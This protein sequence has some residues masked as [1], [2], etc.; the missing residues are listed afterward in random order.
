MAD[1]LGIYTRYHQHEVTHA[2]L[3]LADLAVN[4][5]IAVTLRACDVCLREVT[6]HWDARVKRGRPADFWDWANKCNK[7][8]WMQPPHVQDVVMAQAAGIQAWIFVAWEDLRAEDIETLMHADKVVCPY[9]CVANALIKQNTDMARVDMPWDVPIPLSPRRQTAARRTLL[10]PLFDS[11]PQRVDGTIFYLMHDVLMS[12]PDICIR[13][14]M[15]RG[16]S[17]TARR[18]LKALQKQHGERI[19]VV[20]N[21]RYLQRVALYA[22]ADLTVW[23]SKYESLGLVGLSSLAVGTPVVCW[24]I[25]PHAEYISNKRNG[26]LVPC[27]LKDNWLGVPEVEP[28]YAVFKQYLLDLLHDEVLL[29]TIQQSAHVG[30]AE[31]RER[32]MQGWRNLLQQP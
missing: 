29:G 2:A 26:L 25:E 13:I 17:Q 24:D 11:Q 12:V 10:F 30:M 3:H 14:G 27:E 1:R 6:P 19:T 23:A 7:V 16:W 9:A 18:A 20:R 32:F 28:D 21:P 15:G 22:G 8:L 5:G 4:T 31:R